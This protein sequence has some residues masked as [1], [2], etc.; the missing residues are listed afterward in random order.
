[1]TPLAGLPLNRAFSGAPGSFLAAARP[2]P[3]RLPALA[4]A[5]GRRAIG[6]SSDASASV[7]WT[8]LGFPWSHQSAPISLSNA[9]TL[10]VQVASVPSERLSSWTGTDNVTVPV[11][12][13][14]SGTIAFSS[15]TNQAG[16]TGGTPQIEA[17]VTYVALAAATPEVPATIL[18]PAVAG[19]IAL[20]TVGVTRRRKAASA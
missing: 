9:Q 1:M 12:S 17:C 5:E 2:L 18:L 7:D 13:L 11:V 16:G 15:A 20:V 10:S 14:G 6:A 4:G 3:T 8:A 19:G